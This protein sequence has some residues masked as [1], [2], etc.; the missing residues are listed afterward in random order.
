MV[1]ASHG[2][3]GRQSAVQ[4]GQFEGLTLLGRF[5]EAPTTKG[6]LARKLSPS[7]TTL[8]RHFPLLEWW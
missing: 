5:S 6:G 4:E 2:E 1:Q 3:S 8:G 7:Q